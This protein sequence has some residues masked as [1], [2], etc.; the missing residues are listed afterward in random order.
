MPKFTNPDSPFLIHC[1]IVRTSK[2]NN[3][4]FIP[5]FNIKDSD[6]FNSLEHFEIE[7]ELNN[8]K[9][10]NDQ[11]FSTGLDIYNYMKQTIK[12]I[13]IGITT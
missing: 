12:Y 3:G 11:R 9:I 2:T 5:Q 6:V 7:I 10:D 13:L 8:Y 1:S 4:K